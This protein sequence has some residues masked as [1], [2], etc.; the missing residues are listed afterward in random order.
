MNSRE[1]IW[2]LIKEE[3]H[4]SLLDKGAVLHGHYC[5]GLALGV[6]AASEAMKKLGKKSKGV[7]DVIAIV[8]TNNCLSDGVQVVTGCSFGNNS[9]V[10]KDLGKTA[11][12]VAERDEDEGVRFVAKPDLQRTWSED[13]PGYRELF[14]KVVKERKGSDEEKNELSKLG[15]EVSHHIVELPTEDLFKIETVKVEFPDYAPIHES[16]ICDR[17]DEK[18]MS[19]RTVKKEGETFCLLCGGEE[20]FELDGCGINCKGDKI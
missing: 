6:K 9:L 8:E 2:S 3:G 11:V 10:F 19:T 4:N 12:T 18:V 1:E 17:C 20:F 13:F 15:E 5:P 7:E 14:E 16:Y